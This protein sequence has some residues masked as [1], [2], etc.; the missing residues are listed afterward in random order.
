MGKCIGNRFHFLCMRV[1]SCFKNAWNTRHL[2]LIKS[3]LVPFVSCMAPNTMT[4]V[5]LERFELHL[6]GRQMPADHAAAAGFMLFF[7][8]AV[9]EQRKEVVIRVMTLPFDETKN[10]TKL[11]A[12]RLNVS[13]PE[14]PTDF[15]IT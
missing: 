10:I 2:V 3:F 14:L 12:S 13:P 11:G 7:F 15:N 6:N 5:L 9:A 4:V 1:A 8:F